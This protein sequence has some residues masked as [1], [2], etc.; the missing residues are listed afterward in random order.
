MTR[1]RLLGMEMKIF[2]SRVGW[3]VYAIVPFIILCCMFGPILSHSD[4]WLGIGLSVALCLILLPALMN[5]RYA[6]R[7]NELGI[8]YFFAWNW[9]PIDKIESVKTTSSILAA[10]ALSTHRLAIKFSDRSILK[11]SAPLEISPKDE[12]EFVD[13][14]LR[15]N[16]GIKVII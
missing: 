1:R 6:I 7:G 12:K 3:W 5:I 15:V 4:Y 2:K 16:P 11:S 8:R 14:L 9:F 13:G 10:P